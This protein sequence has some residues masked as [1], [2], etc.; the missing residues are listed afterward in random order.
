MGFGG[1]RDRTWTHEQTQA[2]WYIA[3]GAS[4]TETNVR[5]YPESGHNLN[6]PAPSRNAFLFT[7]L[8]LPELRPY[9]L[10]HTRS[11]STEA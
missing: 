3:L 5:K 4:F 9:L 1:T 8:H 7:V 10:L 6:Q 2:V 11:S